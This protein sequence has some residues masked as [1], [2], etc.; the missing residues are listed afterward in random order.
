MRPFPFQKQVV[1]EMEAF[2]GLTL[3]AAEMGVGKTPM[4]IWYLYRNREKVLPAVVVCPA[5]IKHH[6][7]RELWRVG[8]IE[9]EILESQTPYAVSASAQVVVINYDIL[10]FWTK[11]LKAWKP[12]TV[13]VDECQAL[14]N[15]RAKQT[16][17]AKS[18]FR[19]AEHRIALSG[20][21]LVN[22]PIELWH[23]LN[24]ILPETFFNR[25]EYAH[26]YCKPRRT[27]WGWD[28][29]GA[30]HID[31]LHDLLESKLMIRRR[32]VDVLKDLPPKLRRVIPMPIENRA[33]Y[34]RA[35]KD[36]IAWLRE[37]DPKKVRSARKAEELVKVG[38][39]LRLA[40]RSK[41]KFVIEWINDFLADSDEK[42]IVFAIHKETIQTLRDGCSQ[43]AMV[44][45]GSVPMKNRATIVDRFQT[46]P[47]ARLLIGNIRAMGVGLTLTAASN[48]V[49]AE[50]PWQPG[51]AVQAEDRAHRIGA[52]SD[53]WI[54]YLVAA[55]TI[56]ERLC[57]VLQSKQAVLSAV[58]DGGQTDGD[59]DV[60]DQLIGKW[61][62]K[63]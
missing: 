30:S 47:K 27:P 45:D 20:T 48:V 43:K 17:A 4:T 26:R 35:T 34:E 18:L 55:G 22:R 11:T 60:Y 2:N 8:R 10:R 23:T 13:V 21:P 33:E 46:D 54:W 42:L 5:S 3:L 15:G 50:L 28:F 9:S 61:R 25:L 19:V 62:V 16:R 36:F 37:V 44:I 32:K 51:A 41:S 57:D 31:E 58:L 63:R 39:L 56:E 29:R 53:V 24:A 1:R 38:H 7:Q 6:W 52:E 59:L 12:K 49:F 14:G 40:A